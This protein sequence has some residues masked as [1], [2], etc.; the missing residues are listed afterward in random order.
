MRKTVLTALAVSLLG[1]AAAGHASTIT[2]GTYSLSDVYADGYS[3]TGTVT[4]NASGVVTGADLVLNDASASDPTYTNVGS[5]GSGG[6]DP[7][8]DFAYITGANGQIQ[9][10]YLD[11]LNPN[12][13]V[14]L[15][16]NGVSCNSYQASYIQTY[17]GALG[18]NPVDLT[19]G[20]LVSQSVGATP[21]PSSLALLGTGIL[22][23]AGMV[24]RRFLR[25]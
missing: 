7:V 12:G 19:S 24:R 15:C 23:A 4:F 8:S 13:S 10:Q 17:N 3:I 25:S 6:Y 1:I 2:A 22:G 5:T 14:E 21:E 9:L 20:T 16:I 18:Y 11:T